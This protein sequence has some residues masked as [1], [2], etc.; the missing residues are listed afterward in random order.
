[1]AQPQCI[2]SMR[3]GHEAHYHLHLLL[4]CLPVQKVYLIAVPSSD[5]SVHAKVCIDLSMFTSHAT[6]MYKVRTLYMTVAWLVKY[7][8]TIPALGYC[9]TVGTA[10]VIAGHP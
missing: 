4:S 8:S 1:M 6:A 7:G 9:T 10:I 3:V 2:R 5:A